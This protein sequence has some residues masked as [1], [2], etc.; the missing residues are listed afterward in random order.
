MSS[1]KMSR[2]NSKIS[3]SNFMRQFRDKNTR[4]LKNLTSIQF[5]EVWSHYDHD[6]NGYIEGRELDNFLREFV[7]S[8]NTNDSGPEIVTDSMFAELKEC[9][10]EAYDDN[11]DGKIDIREMAQLLPLDES[12]LLLFR[13]DN[14]LESSVEF[15]K[16]WR[17]Y[18]TDGS[19][20]IEADEL[21]IFDSNKDGKLQLSEMAK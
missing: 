15:M 13:F 3:D 20:F 10:M 1:T 21:K 18:D 16:I 14:P 5:M 9:F 6:G 7:S 8:V 19:G 11:K 17:E 4:Q 12:F 2:T